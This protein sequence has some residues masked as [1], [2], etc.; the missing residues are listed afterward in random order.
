MKKIMLYQHGGSYNHGCEA[1]ATTVSEIITKTVNNS[2]VLLSSSQPHQ[3]KRYNIASIHKIILANIPLRRFTFDYFIYQFNKRILK[4]ANLVYHCLID[5]SCIRHSNEMSAYVAIGGDMYCY[6]KGRSFWRTDEI[7]KKRNKNLVLWGCSVEPDDLPGELAEHL[8]NFDLITARESL[9]YEALIANG[10][11]DKVHLVADP[12]FLLEKE[13]LPLP[14]NWKEGKMV[15]INLS[16]LV[17]DYTDNKEQV[18][19]SIYALIEYIIE[20]TDMNVALIPHVRLK[21]TDDVAVMKPIYDHFK[22]SNRVILFDNM[23][24]GCKQLKGYISRCRF[25]IGARTHSVIAA[26]STY[27]PALALGYSVKANGIAK[28]IFGYSEN[29]VVPVQTLDSPQAVIN[30]F[31]YLVENE[32]AL[33]SHLEEFIPEYK[34]KAKISGELLNK[35]INK[36]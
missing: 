35:L 9:T 33:K 22:A 15:G 26:Y 4:N 31:N 13:E 11:A 2:Q 23:A 29:L 1:L 5:H 8:K 19:Q 7:L 10:L 27:V 25:F 18:V 14:E 28:D 16:P 36:G 17:L 21:G 24:L 12:A 3:D 20:N 6:G 30:C 32:S 34:E